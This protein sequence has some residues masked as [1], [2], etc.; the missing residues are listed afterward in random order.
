MTNFKTS[1][2]RSI[3]RTDTL[4]ISSA[5]MYL[6]RQYIRALTDSLFA[7]ATNPTLTLCKYTSHSIRHS[8]SQTRWKDRQKNDH[9]SRQAKVMDLKSRAA[10]KLLQVRL[11]ADSITDIHYL[12]PLVYFHKKLFIKKIRSINNKILDK[13]KKRE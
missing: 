12:P 2:L 13:K 9:Y 6:T 8:S 3:A 11:I 10:F 1:I 5:I 7:P 4:S